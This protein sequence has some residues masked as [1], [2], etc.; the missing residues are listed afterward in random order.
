MSIT[1]I[2]RDILT[3]IVRY[4]PCQERKEVAKAS[5]VMRNA[6][7]SES[8]WKE[9]CETT[10]PKKQNSSGISWH[11]FFLINKFA[12]NSD[13]EIQNKIAKW[14]KWIDS[15]DKPSEEMQVSLLGGK[16]I[17]A[18]ILTFFVKSLIQGKLE[19]CLM[20]FL[21]ESLFFIIN[22]ACGDFYLGCKKTQSIYN[23]YIY[24]K[25]HTNLRKRIEYFNYMNS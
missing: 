15:L 16:A 19:E 2:P 10:F 3:S 1:S 9:E 8:L 12:E 24:S 22:L 20:C 13:R 23:H 5:R 11:R 7:S 25:E 17:M 18:I 21:V 4:I 6:I 14:D